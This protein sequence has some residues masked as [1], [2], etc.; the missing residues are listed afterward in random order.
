MR[1][2]YIKAEVVMVEALP[3]EPGESRLVRIF[4]SGGVRVVAQAQL[5]GEGYRP[6]SQHERQIL[7]QTDAEAAVSS[8]SD[9]DG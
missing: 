1:V 4:S 2:A 3:A 8:I 6:L 7:E 9:G 5:Y